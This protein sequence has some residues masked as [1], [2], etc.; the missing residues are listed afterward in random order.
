M[1]IWTGCPKKCIYTL[2]AYNSIV[3]SLQI[4][5]IGNGDAVEVLRQP[6]LT[7][8]FPLL[9]LCGALSMSGVFWNSSCGPSE[10]FH[11]L[12]TDL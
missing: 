5:P 8:T 10:Q 6:F 2:S 12:Q 7:F 11:K 1:Y 9:F 4:K 3:S